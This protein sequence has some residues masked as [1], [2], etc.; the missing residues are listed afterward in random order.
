MPSNPESVLI[1]VF[2]LV[3]IISPAHSFEDYSFLFWAGTLAMASKYVL[4]LKKKHILNPAAIAVILTSFV[5]GQSASW[6][7]GSIYLVPFVLIG[8]ILVVRKI[9]RTELVTSFILVTLVVVTVHSLIIG[10]NIT[11]VWSQI[12]IYSP[13]LFFAFVMLTEPMTTPPNGKRRIIYGAFVGLIFAP[14]A[15]I[16]A[17]YSTPELAL[18]IGNILS[19]LISSKQKLILTL[20]DKVI[21]A[22]GVWDF[23]FF[24]SEKLSFKPG[25]YMEFTV[26]HNKADNRGIRRFF[27]I[28]SSPTENELI[29][30][31]KFYDNSSS[32]KRRLIGMNKTETIM[33]S[34]LAGD[35][36]L[37]SDKNEKLVFIAGGI[38]V[39]PFRSMIKYLVDKGER[40][41]IILLYSTPAIEDI[42]Y[43]DVFDQATKIIGL[44]VVNV[45]TAIDN[46]PSDWKGRRGMINEQMIT[47]DV[48]DFKERTFYISG[49]HAMVASFKLVLKNMGVKESH[50]KT[51]YFPGFV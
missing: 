1:T 6:W 16:G 13:F 35:F 8:G 5:L 49:P 7:V 10:Q 14:F 12:V 27:T 50:I 29:L 17:I 18:I 36:T 48:P 31:L 42:A 37:P 21:Q 24:P 43:R 4:A 41:D 19:Y 9:R 23:I 25:Q 32:F 46:L 40:R 47:E 38:G 20:K 34:Q 45:L 11:T 2:I 15:H 51:D 3:L 44:K 30:G 33:A 22:K 39:T 28:A 26:G